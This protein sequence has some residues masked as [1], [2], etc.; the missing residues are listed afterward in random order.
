M[1]L[2]DLAKAPTDGCAHT[3]RRPYV[4]RLF[5]GLYPP[6]GPPGRGP[7]PAGEGAGPAA[8]PE[9]GPGA[10]PGA[11]KRRLLFFQSGYYLDPELRRASLALGH[12]TAS[13]DIEDFKDPLKDR[14]GDY[15]RLL[16]AIKSF[17]PEMVLTV[18]HLGF[19]TEGLL[20]S[21]L[22]RLGI[23]A[24][25]WFVDIPWYILGGAKLAPYPGLTAFSWDS[26]YLGVLRDLGFPR[27][28]HL[29]L[30]TDEGVFPGKGPPGGPAPGSQRDIAFVGDSLE[31]AT[32]KYLRLAG[33]GPE[34]LP[35]VDALARAFLADP[36]SIPPAPLLEGAGGLL[37]EATGGALALSA[38]VT[39]RAS[40]L[41][42][43]RVLQRMPRGRL[44][45]A[46]DKAWAGLVP[47]A[48]LPGPV[49]YYRGL[50]GFYRGTKVNLNI[51]SAQ[52][53]GGLNQRVFD[54][55]AAGGF[56]LTDR[57]AQLSGLFEEGREV[58]S[59]AGPGEAR[60]LARFY[61]RNAPA[62]ERVSRAARGIILRRHLYR[63]RLPEIVARTL[64][65]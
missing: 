49:D 29:P 18:N 13:W 46:G 63:H 42:R 53:K 20:S 32:G 11:R 57:R 58:V 34:S 24:A 62:R 37:A 12:D 36:A 23:P 64:G 14:G 47:W 39:W 59:Y 33:L 40:R 60:E 16:E 45:I 2:G 9:P 19:D 48:A 8:P 55:P 41:W 61:L 28:F 1:V 50:A 7:G 22:A 30:A 5:P 25:S 6:L 38:L 35:R 51:T 27:A 15:R 54:V 17:R 21:I 4:P 26:D 3:L 44:S 56:L 52:M 31:A 65:G 43:V 10:R